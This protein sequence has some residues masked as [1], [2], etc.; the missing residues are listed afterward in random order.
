MSQVFT[1]TVPGAVISIPAGFTTLTFVNY[2][3]SSQL[4]RV[5]T[6]S[7]P[8]DYP[9]PSVNGGSP[10]ITPAAGVT[11]LSVAYN[12]GFYP[13]AGAPPPQASVTAPIICTAE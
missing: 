2:A 12:N 9:I 7:G 4:V 11:G 1:L 13:V 8:V 3:Q 6:N 10:V 5:Y